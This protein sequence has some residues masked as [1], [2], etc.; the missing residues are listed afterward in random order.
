MK[1]F[2]AAVRGL[3]NSLSLELR[4]FCRTA[5]TRKGYAEASLAHLQQQYDKTEETYLRPQSMRKQLSD[6]TIFEFSGVKMLILEIKHS[7]R[8]ADFETA[9]K[10][11]IEGL[12]A[13]RNVNHLVFQDQTKSYAR[14]KNRRPI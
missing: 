11:I 10:K 14:S 13:M 9:H 7:V 12:D 1:G 6:D 3:L 4:S 2:T 8:T 5:K